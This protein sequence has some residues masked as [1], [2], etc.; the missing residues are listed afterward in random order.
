MQQGRVVP[1]TSELALAAA[2][3]SLEFSLPMADSL[4]LATARSTDAEVWTQEA[5][6]ATA[7]PD[8]A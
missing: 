4:I 6:F 8:D 7:H 3:L 5:D 1:L 2:K